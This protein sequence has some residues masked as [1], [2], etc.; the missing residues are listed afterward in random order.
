MILVT[1]Y[2]QRSGRWPP[3]RCLD[4]RIVLPHSIPFVC[5]SLHIR[6][7]AILYRPERCPHWQTG[8]QD[9][10]PLSG[11][12]FI[13]QSS[14]FSSWRHSSGDVVFTTCLTNLYQNKMAKSNV[15]FQPFYIR[16]SGVKRI[17]YPVYFTLQNVHLPAFAANV[18][19]V[20]RYLHWKRYRY[21]I[22]QVLVLLYQIEL[23]VE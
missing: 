10:D 12:E 21:V 9:N 15:W 4:D 23:A 1:C 2:G 19:I 14:E 18:V 8:C 5:I 13:H 17:Q 11:T 6:P 3:L 20:S 7:G 16:V 22:H